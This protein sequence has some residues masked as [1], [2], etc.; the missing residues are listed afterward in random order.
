MINA[1]TYVNGIGLV[2]CLV[3]S[4]G[5]ASKSPSL[6]AC[7]RYWLKMTDDNAEKA[8]ERYEECVDMLSGLKGRE[9]R[10]FRESLMRNLDRTATFFFERTTLP[11][12]EV[13]QVMRSVAKLMDVLGENHVVSKYNNPLDDSPERKYRILF[14][15]FI[16]LV[17]CQTILLLCLLWRF[18]FI[19]RLTHQEEVYLKCRRRTSYCESSSPRPDC[20]LKDGED[21]PLINKTK[22]CTF[23]CSPAHCDK[24]RPKDEDILTDFS[25]LSSPGI[26][27]DSEFEALMNRRPLPKPKSTADNK[28]PK[29]GSKSNGHSTFPK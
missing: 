24:M 18:C 20:P 11:A 15:S 26:G 13:V 9:K 4:L 5:L 12:A 28:I 3:A 29:R 16:A 6:Q 17:T 2:L 10:L 27:S 25:S 7:S 8:L 23:A 22:Q 14:H 19:K 21:F 1:E